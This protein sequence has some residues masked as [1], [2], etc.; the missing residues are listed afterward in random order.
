M[1]AAGIWGGCRRGE[2]GCGFGPTLEINNN[3]TL[4]DA[5]LA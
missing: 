1:A 5:D 2:G 3:V 4:L